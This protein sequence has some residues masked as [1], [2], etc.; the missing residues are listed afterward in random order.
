MTI[1]PL[2]N[3]LGVSETR[4]KIARFTFGRL[5]IVEVKCS[6]HSIDELMGGWQT[7]VKIAK[8][9]HSGRENKTKIFLV[10][11]GLLRDLPLESRQQCV[12]LRLFYSN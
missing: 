2:L 8:K 6:K 12:W 10:D 3:V 4:R 7:T 9:V 5:T 1:A 11:L